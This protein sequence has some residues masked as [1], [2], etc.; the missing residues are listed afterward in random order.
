MTE[1]AAPT[2]PTCGSHLQPIHPP[3]QPDQVVMSCPKHGVPPQG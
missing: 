2:C 1:P 3:A